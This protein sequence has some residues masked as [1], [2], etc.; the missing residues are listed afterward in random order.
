MEEAKSLAKIMITIITP[1]YNRSGM[2]TDAIESVLTQGFQPFE[3]II[4]DGG[5]TDGT[6][7]ILKQYPH[8]KVI[9]ESDQG[10][11]DALNKGLAA[12]K[13]EIIGFLNTD[14]LYADHFFADVS[15]KFDDETVMAVA[16]RAIV[17]S[18]LPEGKNKIVDK[19]SPE[20]RSLIECSTIGSNYFNAWFFRRS[21]FDQIGKF[22]TSYKIV[23]DRDFMLR[24][25]LSNLRYTFINDLVYKY[26]QHEDSLTF[27]KNGQ[28]R[29]W[30]ADEHL[31]MTS[32]YL[33][34]QDLSGRARK[35]LVQLRTLE[36]VDLAARSLWMLNYKKFV[37]Y[38]VEGFRYDPAWPLRFI[39]YVLKRGVAMILAKRSAIS[40]R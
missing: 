33:G 27:D 17:F 4:V 40:L 1:S 38:T 35:L 12:S 14:D 22:N 8:L 32:L 25:A 15:A 11:Y 18:E 21:L 28:K 13:G 31:A 36:T 10:M 26:R 37:H 29:E 5:S 16:G 23:G 34:D 19:Y 7:E 9:S 20:D 6:L 2:I 39:Q 3:H 30:S 24:F